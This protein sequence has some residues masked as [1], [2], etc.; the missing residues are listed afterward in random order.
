VDGG[1]G[2][3]DKARDSEN[4]AW[5]F[6][7]SG[8]STTRFI[9]ASAKI[10]LR[11][12]DFPLLSRRFPQ[13]S[14]EH[15]LISLP[16]PSLSDGGSVVGVSDFLPAEEREDVAVDGGFRTDDAVLEDDSLMPPG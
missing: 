14:E 12:D 11:L 13:A 6:C 2:R 1:T 16:R 8:C 15:R 7:R 3:F 9:R 5:G 10:D 4:F